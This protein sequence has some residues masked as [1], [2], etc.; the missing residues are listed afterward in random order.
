MPGLPLHEQISQQ[1]TLYMF[2]Y[3]I[4]L[5]KNQ[6]KIQC[7]F[8]VHFHNVKREQVWQNQDRTQTTG[9][10]SVSCD[11]FGP[12]MCLMRTSKL[13]MQF[14]QQNST[15]DHS[16]YVPNIK[17]VSS[18]MVTQTKKFKPV[19]AAKNPARGASFYRTA[20]PTT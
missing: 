6:S 1:T 3:I 12:I 9:F 5:V 14:Q 17:A 11:H 18:Y 8:F 13:H 7:L 16:E 15:V 4:L 20:G 19:I 10:N 2:A